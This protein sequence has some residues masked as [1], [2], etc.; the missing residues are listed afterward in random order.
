[1]RR[2]KE[3]F[4]EIAGL[5]EVALP[6]N[7]TVDDMKRFSAGDAPTRVTFSIEQPN[8]PN[9]GPGVMAWNLPTEVELMRTDRCSEESMRPVQILLEH[10]RLLKERWDRKELPPR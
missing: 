6:N 5:P 7:W 8:G 3:A 1:M 4:A 2:G 10:G 9:M